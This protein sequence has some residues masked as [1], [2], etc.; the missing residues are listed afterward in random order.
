MFTTGEFVGLGEWII[1]DTSYI[2]KKCQLLQKSS[3]T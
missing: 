1:D 3:T 2:W